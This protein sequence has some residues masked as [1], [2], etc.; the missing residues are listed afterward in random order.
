MIIR[1]DFYHD[2]PIDRRA[3]RLRLG[4]DP[5]ASPVS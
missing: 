2:A 4:L 3:E 1:P 5:V